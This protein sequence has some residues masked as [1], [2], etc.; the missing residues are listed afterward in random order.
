[1]SHRIR[2]DCRLC[3]STDLTNVLEL[4]PTPP[5]NEFLPA[6][7]VGDQDTFPLYLAQ[8]KA[9]GHVQLPVVVD[10]ERLFRNYV[11]VSGT[12]PSFVKHFEDYAQACISEHGLSTGDLVVDVGSNDGTLLRFFQ[13]SGMRV[14]GVDPAVAIADKATAEGIDTLPQFFD[15]KTARDIHKVHG[16]AS[17]VVA[18]NV[19]AHADDLREIALGARDLLDPARGR[20]VFEVQYLVDLVEKTLFDMVYHEHL[21]YHHLAPLIPFFDSMSMTLVDAEHVDT[22]GG[23]IRCTVATRKGRPQSDRLTGMLKVEQAALVGEPFFELGRRIK[24]TGEKIRDFLNDCKDRGETVCGYGAP[25]KLTTLCHEFGITRD[26]IAVVIDD[27]PWKQGLHTPGTR[28][29]V[30]GINR[31]EYATSPPALVTFAWNFAPQ[32]AAKLRASGYTGRIVTPL[33]EFK[34][35]P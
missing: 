16:A 33:P 13:N 32:I 14:V 23:S 28:I 2:K 6:D 25:A 19:F 11:Y 20:F 29:P 3:G 21:S 30:I 5:A 26:D 17:L 7:F 12:S 24:Y 9:C 4:A 27:S 15:R 34:E 1:V 22:H 35:L 31:L 10:P 18:N 8:C